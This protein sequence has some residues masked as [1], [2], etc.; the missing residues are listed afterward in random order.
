MMSESN[1]RVPAGAAAAA[2]MRSSNGGGSGVVALQQH[3]SPPMSQC[4]L[5]SSSDSSPVGIPGVCPLHTLGSKFAFA[6]TFFTFFCCLK[7]PPPLSLCAGNED[8]DSEL[9]HAC[10]GPLISLPPVNSLVVYWPQGHLEQVESALAT[11]TL[12]MSARASSL[13]FLLKRRKKHFLLTLLVYVVQVANCT[14][15]AAVQPPI[16]QYN[17]PPHILCRLTD[18]TLMVR[19]FSVCIYE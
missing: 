16:P 17:L 11:M 9:W 12:Y 8:L 2:T 18:I 1:F 7:P 10:A 5:P 19:Q 15:Q 6:C 4:P 3:I 13:V 14:P